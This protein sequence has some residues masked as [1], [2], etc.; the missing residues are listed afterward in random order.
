MKF[1][2]SWRMKKPRIWRSVVRW[3]LCWESWETLSI[4]YCVIC[5]RKSPIIKAARQQVKPKRKISAILMSMEWMLSL[6]IRTSQIR[7]TWATLNPRTRKTRTRRWNRLAVEL[8]TKLTTVKGMTMTRIWFFIPWSR[9]LL[10]PAKAERRLR[11]PPRSPE[12]GGR[13]PCRFGSFARSSTSRKPVCPV[14][15]NVQLLAHSSS[16]RKRT[17]HS[18]VHQTQPGQQDRAKRARG[19]N[20]GRQSTR[21]DTLQVEWGRR[22]R[23]PRP[24][25]NLYSF[26]IKLIL[27]NFWFFFFNF[28]LTFDKNIKNL[29]KSG[30]KRRKK[31][32]SRHSRRR[33]IRPSWL[34]RTWNR[35]RHWRWMSFSSKVAVTYGEQEVQLP[36]GSRK[37]KRATRKSTSLRRRSFQCPRVKNWSKSL[38]CQKTRIPLEGYESLNRIQSKLM[39]P[40]QLGPEFARLCAN[41]SGKNQ[42][43]PVDH[44]ARDRKTH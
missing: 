10:A 34:S 38:I 12:E 19:A 28:F 18:L 4:I 30:R 2:P 17:N 16:M 33:P 41:R 21:A 36:G 35:L 11:R 8:E 13:S 23:W 29:E 22:C 20:E 39:E 15:L 24:G 44:D 31:R 7:R 43:C 9:R 40:G 3:S 26:S 5:R 27:K 25:F 14:A 1:W 6:T 37:T 42:R 32:R